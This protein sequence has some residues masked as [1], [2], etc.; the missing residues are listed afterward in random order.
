VSLPLSLICVCV[1]LAFGADSASGGT[2]EVWT[3]AD[4]ERLVYD[5]VNGLGWPAGWRPGG[6][7]GKF[8]SAASCEHGIPSTSKALTVA[9]ISATDGATDGAWSF[10]APPGVLIDRVRLWRDISLTTPGLRAGFAYGLEDA[11]SSPCAAGLGG[12]GVAAGD[13]FATQRRIE[14]QPIYARNE[15]RVFLSCRL[16]DGCAS[17]SD[18]DYVAVYAARLTL[19][20]TS[21]PVLAQPPSG[22]LLTA[23][24]P[25]SGSQT[26]D[27]GATDDGAGV[28]AFGL[29]VDGTETAR[30]PVSG[31]PTCTAPFNRPQPC[32]AST[33]GSYGFDTGT[34]VDGRHTVR[35]KAI[36]ASGNEAA[37]A[38]V[39]IVTQNR[40]SGCRPAGPLITARL[41]RAGRTETI[42]FG[43]RATVRG[44]VRDGSGQPLAHAQVQVVE[45]P[46]LAGSLPRV[47]RTVSSDGR[48][49]LRFALRGGPSREI[50]LGI[51]AGA[52]S[53]GLICSPALRLRVRAGI[54]LSVH[55]RR[56]SRNGRIQFSGRLRGRP[57][58]K[59]VQ[60]TIYAVAR[61]GR[62]RV[63]VETVQT[64]A[65]G[66]FGFKYR[67]R[68]SFAPF[69]YRFRARVR[70]QLG[71]PYA[72]AWSGTVV[73]RIVR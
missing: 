12:R 66:R 34:L 20:D 40:D 21:A 60:V 32:P 25:V 69:T 71:Y 19:S 72:A 14:Y 51:P 15:F 24:Q 73:V 45:R 38:P 46:L 39:G 50:R 70:Q 28:A 6:T 47:T 57:K 10:A 65:R 23:P 44:R 31:V 13:P 42:R 59:D 9:T 62:A 68:R 1:V 35:V 26:I 67:F 55:P 7:S 43:R 63:P 11:C 8:I 5:G 16:A 49:R 64:G 48:G 58:T 52:G 22:S 27:V 41:G 18:T 29:E 37:S 3:C 61:R 33:A 2:Y 56:V 4:P 36:D 53:T 17:G 30:W 54:T